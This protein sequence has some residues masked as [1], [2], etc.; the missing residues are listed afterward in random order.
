MNGCIGAF[1][2]ENKAVFTLLC[3]DAKSNLLPV[4]DFFDRLL[5]STHKNDSDLVIFVDIW[6]ITFTDGIKLEVWT[7]VT[8]FT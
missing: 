1:D 8:S 3:L 2:H 4:F 6:F 5:T 7:R